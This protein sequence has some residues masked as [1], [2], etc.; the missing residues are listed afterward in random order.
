[1]KLS[2]IYQIANSIASKSI[3]DELC[4]KYGAYDNS[5]VLVDCGKE[6]DKILFALDL[7]KGAIEKAI[8]LGA[9]LIITH[10]PAIY[11]KIANI[12]VGDINPLGEKL[13]ACLQNGISVLSMHLNLDAADGGIDQSLQE[14]ILR[15]AD[16]SA[17][18][19][20]RSTQETRYFWEI[21][22]GKYGRVYGVKECSLSELCENLKK[23]FETN[24]IW[25][26]GDSQKRIGKAASFCGS[27]GGDG[28]AAFAIANGADVIISAE[29]KHHVIALC[30]ER[31][32]AVV[33]MTHYASEYYG[34]KKYYEKMSRQVGIECFCF[35]ED[36]L[37]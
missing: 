4:Q 29:F 11:A 15:S 5:G 17:G 10:H 13:V 1:M 22:Q 6:I 21:S 20:L 26:F 37:L 33:Q 14:G 12:R 19:G 2:E 36:S 28:E 25:V 27:G 3:S 31:G 30:Q 32:V 16:E 23:T 35:R 7:T 34:F 9:Q 24:R 8:A 18:A